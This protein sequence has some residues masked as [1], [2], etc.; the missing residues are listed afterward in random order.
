M[1]GTV[2]EVLSV[3]FTV[4]WDSKHWPEFVMLNEEWELL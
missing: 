4:V 3:Q 2:D 1:M